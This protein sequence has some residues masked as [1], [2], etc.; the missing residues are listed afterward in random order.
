MTDSSIGIN[1]IQKLV[2]VTWQV[3]LIELLTKFV[4]N[5][6]AESFYLHSLHT[7]N[8]HE[9][10]NK[11][12]KYTVHVLTKSFWAFIFPEFEDSAKPSSVPFASRWQWS[13]E[14]QCQCVYKIDLDSDLPKIARADIQDAVDRKGMDWYIVTGTVNGLLSIFLSICNNQCVNI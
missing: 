4:G 12:R 3:T 8:N 6:F 9:Q 1:C 5:D 2:L 7:L 10:N 14:F 13:W 11:N